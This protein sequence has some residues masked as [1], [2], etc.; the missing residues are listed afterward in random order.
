MFGYELEEL[1]GEKVNKLLPKPY[2]EQHDSYLHNYHTTGHKRIIGKSRLVEGQHKD[3]SIFPIRL[4]VSEVQMEGAKV[5]I[6]MIDRVEDTAGTVTANSEGT[7]ISC[8]KQ[9]EAIW[10]YSVSELVG[11]NLSV[12]MPSP[13][14]ERHDQYIAAYR[15]TGIM[16]VIN[17]TRNVPAQH[18]NGAVFPVSLQVTMLKVGAVELFKG[19]VEKVDTE[20]EAVFTIN[21]QGYIVSCNR[22]FLTPLFGYTDAELI[23]HHIHVLVPSF[24]DIISPSPPVGSPT[25]TTAVSSRKRKRAS[26]GGAQGADAETH[27]IGDCLDTVQRVE[28]RDAGPRES[29]QGAESGEVPPDRHKE[30]EEENGAEDLCG[31]HS[32]TAVYEALQFDSSWNL[33]GQRR[34]QVRHKDG[35][36]FPVDFAI[37][38][39]VKDNTGTSFSTRDNTSKLLTGSRLSSSQCGILVAFGA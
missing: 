35:S 19:R 20:M 29:E 3:G 36:V 25:A 9:C 27:S 17:H 12:L 18:K 38:K 6:G 37:S 34:L 22:N 13:H 5:F 31:N 14:R 4:A 32:G 8:N 24:A 21:Q 7:I 23:G 16:K 26:E 10:G 33:L 39:F 30:E 15:R 28:A 2:C 1:M 11:K